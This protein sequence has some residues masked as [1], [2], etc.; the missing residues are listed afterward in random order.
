MYFQSHFICKAIRFF[1]LLVWCIL[2][3][4][5]RTIWFSMRRTTVGYFS[6]YSSWISSLYYSYPPSTHHQLF[7]MHPLVPIAILLLL[8]WRHSASLFCQ[9][10]SQC[11]WATAS[12][13]LFSDGHCSPNALS[14]MWAMSLNVIRLRNILQ[15]LIAL[16]MKSKGLS[17]VTAFSDLLL[18]QC[19]A[20]P[21]PAFQASQIHCNSWKGPHALTFTTSPICIPS[22]GA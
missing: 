4:R 16:K 11:S 9:P 6:W 15:A 3:V 13:P 2:P 20:C 19:L 17:A 18:V 1:S 5:A 10:S 14:K 7:Q 12:P 21:L 8:C 22:P